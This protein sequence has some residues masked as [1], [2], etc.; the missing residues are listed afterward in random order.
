MDS[1]VGLSPIEMVAKEVYGE[2]CPSEAS[3][4]EDLRSVLLLLFERAAASLEADPLSPETLRRIREY[5]VISE[6]ISAF[7]TTL[8]ALEDIER[9]ELTRTAGHRS[10]P[11]S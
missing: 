6:T 7:G 1:R 10:T 2:Y 8:K 11:L 5:R 9:H 3:A 4:S